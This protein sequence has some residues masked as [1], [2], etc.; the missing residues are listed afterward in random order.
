M[1]YSPQGLK[2]SDTAE[3]TEY[4]HMQD[5]Q[6]PN[7]W[8]FLIF[9]VCPKTPNIYRMCGFLPPDPCFPFASHIQLSAYANKVKMLISHVRL[10]VTP[11]DYSQPG[12]SIHGILQARILERVR[13]SLLQVIFLT[14]GLNQDLLPYRWILYHLNH[15]G[16]HVGS[17]DNR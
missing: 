3:E 17:S 16:S 7:I 12:S 11:M 14:Q 15:E 9:F 13:H 1:G 4:S 6:P 10:F 8:R 5:T 2:E